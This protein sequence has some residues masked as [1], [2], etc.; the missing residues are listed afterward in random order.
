MEE[1]EFDFEGNQQPKAEVLPTSKRCQN[2]RNVYLW[3]YW[4]ICE[5]SDILAAAKDIHQL[6]SILSLNFMARKF[7]RLRSFKFDD[8]MGGWILWQPSLN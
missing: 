6:L 1:G 7:S 3:I 2:K 8:G 5:L 4:Y